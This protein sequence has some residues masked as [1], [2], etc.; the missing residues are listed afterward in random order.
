MS[1]GYWIV[2]LSVDDADAYQAYRQEVAAFLATV[3]GRF[4][5]RGGPQQV[6]E[7]QARPRTVVIEFPS[8]QAAH[9]CYASDAY[10]R[11]KAMR[12][13]ISAAD[14]VIVEGWDA[15]S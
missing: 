4:L 3:G 12:E 8:A 13:S 10:R 14:L 9:E 5:V 7:G 11:I 15:T 1:K 6:V 2:H